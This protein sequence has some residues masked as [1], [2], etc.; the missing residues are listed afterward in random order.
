M[1][2]DN[3][4][5]II[6]HEELLK[7]RREVN[8]LKQHP[9][10][11]TSTGKEL[12]E[13]IKELNTNISNLFN[14]FREAA[15][16]MKLEESEA[17]MVAEKMKPM[18][19]KFDTLIDQNEKIAK[20]IVAVADMVKE[21]VKKKLRPLPFRMAVPPQRDDSEFAVPSLSSGSRP[22]P[23]FGSMPPPLGVPPDASSPMGASQMPLPMSG[24][25]PSG[26][27]RFNVPP[28][29]LPGSPYGR[30]FQQPPRAPGPEHSES[31]P[32]LPPHAPDKKHHLFG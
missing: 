17:K 16:E 19:Q 24:P 9:L 2:E 13:T 3:D 21:D 29:G 28:A 10:G 32:P 12:L 15:E 5:D 7:L 31:L 26:P 6:P 23:P 27:A 1:A 30:N 25:M 8:E 14:L 20:G 4:Y 11:A 22:I 18:M